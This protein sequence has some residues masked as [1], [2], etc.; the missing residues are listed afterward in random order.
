[1]PLRGPRTTKDALESLN[2]P[3]TEVDLILVNRES[4]GFERLLHDQ[5]RLACYPMFEAFDITP[6]QHLRPRPLRCPVF[7]CDVHLGVLARRMRLLGCDVSYRNDLDDAV[8]IEIQEQ[9]RRAILTRD[10]NLLRNHRVR[11]GCLIR[12]SNPDCQLEQVLHRFDLSTSLAPFTRC[13]R[14]NGLLKPVEREKILKLLPPRVALE[15]RSFHICPNCGQVYWKGSHYRR[16][17]EWVRRLLNQ[18]DGAS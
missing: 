8:I 1:M 10:R 17:Q 12:S 2:I 5:D 14:C 3:H 4:V 13:S 9:E 18:Y 7:I 15:R 6:V 11:W 16:L